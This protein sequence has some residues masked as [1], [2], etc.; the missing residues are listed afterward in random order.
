[1]DANLKE[2]EELSSQLSS[3]AGENESGPDEDVA[4]SSPSREW[5]YREWFLLGIDYGL[6]QTNCMSMM[7]EF[8]RNPGTNGTRSRSLTERVYDAWWLANEWNLDSE[9]HCG[10]DVKKQVEKWCAEA[11]LFLQ[12]RMAY[13][14]LETFGDD[15]PPEDEVDTRRK[16]PP[17]PLSTD[18]FDYKKSFEL[19]MESKDALVHQCSLNNARL[20]GSVIVDEGTIR[21]D[22]DEHAKTDILE[23]AAYLKSRSESNA[24]LKEY[25]RKM[26][27]FHLEDLLQYNS[28]MAFINADKVN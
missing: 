9:Q 26:V 28:E 22:P 3:S 8:L 18:W 10:P 24:S 23:H 11:S 5:Q 1:M 14:N 6:L 2:Y 27:S 4:E 17:E 13:L 21:D 20:P 15:L 12:N 19:L 16:W 25:W 7:K